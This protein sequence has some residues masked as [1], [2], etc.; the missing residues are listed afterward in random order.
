VG[1]PVDAARCPTC[2]HAEGDPLAAG[3]GDV[4]GGAA[5]GRRPVLIGVLAVLAIVGVLAV[6]DRRE[7]S[8]DEGAAGEPANEVTTTTDRSTATSRRTSA[9]TTPP[10]RVFESA[11]PLPPGHRLIGWVAPGWGEIL[12]PA[13]GTIAS[14]R[15]ASG[16]EFISVVP[17]LG[18]AVVFNGGSTTA[19]WY[20]Q[21]PT[22]DEPRLLQTGAA[23][24]FASDIASRVWI[25]DG[26][27]PATFAEFDVSTGEVS[28]E[29]RLPAGAWPRGTIDGGL[30]I[31]AAGG[32]FAHRRGESRF[33]P[34]ASGEYVA[35]AGSLVAYRAC[36]EFLACPVYLH[37]LADGSE[38]LIG[39]AD[40]IPAAYF[41]DGEFS[42][43]GRWLA[44]R[45]E[46]VGGWRILVIETATGRV[47]PAGEGP[48]RQSG[49]QMAWTP[50]DEWLLWPDSPG[51]RGFHPAD[52]TASY[53]DSAGGGAYQGVAVLEVPTAG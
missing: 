39:R 7:G 17:R 42:P 48:A 25:L 53:I 8:D 21:L 41:I 33:E 28:S 13:T 19:Q 43:G 47:L 24:V 20:P 30:V 26:F 50:D 5:T 52:N 44:L 1:L 29:V 32:L 45:T 10:D 15:L 12:D 27:D 6:V 22:G 37:D 3:D 2:G 4:S 51:L 16:S 35:S 46:E 38:S 23:E 49:F 31:Q 36:D 40:E 9:P 34:I 11:I 18:G 14:T